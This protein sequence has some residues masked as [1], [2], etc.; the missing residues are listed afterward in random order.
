MKKFLVSMLCVMVAVAGVVGGAFMTKPTYVSMAAESEAKEV[1]KITVSGSGEVR[2]TPDLAIIS[3][4]VETLNESLELAQKENS[5]SVNSVI[6]AL[7]EMGVSEENI[8]T[9]N[10]YVYQ[11]YDYSKGE[12]FLGYQVS[13]YIDFKTKDIDN[14]GSIITKLLDSGA[15][16]FQGISFTLENEEE[17]YNMALERALENAK[18]KASAITNLPYSSFEVCEDCGYN[19]YAREVYSLSSFSKESTSIMKGEICV[20]A[21]IRVTF[22]Y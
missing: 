17:A 12:N 1:Q 18:S 22:E 10:F 14:V 4:G 7:K 11:R 15:N 13:N 2:L 16:R 21:S 6:S 9:K 5:D 19:C 20:K 3:L 8:K